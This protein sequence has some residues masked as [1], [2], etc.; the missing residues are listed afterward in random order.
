M[1]PCMSHGVKCLH[2]CYMTVNVSMHVTW[3]K[4][5][6]HISHGGECLHTYHTAV[7]ASMHVTWRSMSPCMSHDSQCLH[8]CHMAVNV[9]MH[10]AWYQMSPYISHRGKCIHTYHMVI[11]VDLTFA[12]RYTSKSSR[13]N[14]MMRYASYSLH[15][16]LRF[17][18][19]MH[20]ISSAR[21]QSA[22]WVK[23][24]DFVR[25]FQKATVFF[26]DLDLLTSRC[27]C[28]LVVK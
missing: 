12:K 11:C 28:R 25:T 26:V 7:N 18:R 6:P 17:S 9:S 5:S 21:F 10:T 2:A 13:Y 23:R 27:S 15:A 16:R 1:S 19:C 14:A 3:C 24:R 4:M 22:S 8:A 20:E